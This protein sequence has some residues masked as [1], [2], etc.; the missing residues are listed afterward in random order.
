MRLAEP[1]LNCEAEEEEEEKKR[2]R[3]VT[4]AVYS[5]LGSSYAARLRQSMVGIDVG[6][7]AYRE[8]GIHTPSHSSSFLSSSK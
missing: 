5:M 7:V 6:R 2:E 3:V 4:A 8:P 1:V